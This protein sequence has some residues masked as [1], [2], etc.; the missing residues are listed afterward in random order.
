MAM[1]EYLTNLRRHVGH[2]L[3]LLPAVSGVIF[4]AAGELLLGRRADTGGWSLPAGMVDPGEQPADAL[5]REV[6]EEAGIEIAVEHLVGVAMHSVTY[7]NQDRCDYLSVWFRC[8]HLAGEAVVNDEESLDMRWFALD[9]LPDMEDFA[10]LRIDRTLRN[11]PAAWFT[12]PGASHP[13]L[14]GRHPV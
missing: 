3:V 5:V 6:R 12:Q 14:T 2:D 7:P 11:T 8:R 1:S 10:R 4:N 13:A 9:A